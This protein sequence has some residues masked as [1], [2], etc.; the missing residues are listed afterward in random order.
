MAFNREG[1]TLSGC[2]IQWR[3]IERVGHCPVFTY[4]GVQWRGWD[5]VRLLHTVAFNREGGTLS[6]CYIQWRSIERV[7]YCP[8]ATYSGVQ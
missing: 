4:S 2:Y 1:G 3:S 5:I 6:G 8:V 7:G